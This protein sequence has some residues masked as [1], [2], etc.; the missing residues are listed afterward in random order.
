VAARVAALP[1]K[2]K[3]QQVVIKDDNLDQYLGP[4]RFFRDVVE[5][6][7]RPGVVVGLAYTPVGGE[8]LFIEASSMPGRGTLQLT[9][10]LGD[11]MS[12]SVRIAHTWIRSSADRYQIPQELLAK[13]DL[14]LHVPGGA[15]PKDGP[16]AGVAMVCALL[17]LLW[18]G[19]GRAA[20]ARVGMTGEITLRGAV[21]PVGGIKEKVIGARQ[22]GIKT[23]VMPKR[24]EPD[25][26]EIPEQVIRGVKFVFVDTIEEAVRAVIGPVP[27]ERRK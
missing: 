10:K 16:S 12:E 21:L 2:K 22:A 7:R 26:R 8:I 24:N 25:V 15:V 17:S 5:R 9:G 11:V 18:R 23:I 6:T 14:H 13:G 3:P 1:A 19:K 27:G 4:R 20:R